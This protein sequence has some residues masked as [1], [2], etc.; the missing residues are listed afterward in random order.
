ME[1]SEGSVTKDEL[2]RFALKKGQVLLTKDS[3]SWDDIAIPAYVTDNM[4]EV[5][6]GYH[7]AIA[8]PFPDDLDGAYLAWLART[9]V[10]NDQF[11]L[12]ARGVTRFGLSQY[13]LKNA[14]L[15]VPP[16][17]EQRRIAE[18]LDEK[19]FEI[20]AL[21]E[22]KR[23]LLDLLAEKRSAIITNAVTKGINPGAPTK[24]CG[25]DWL[26]RVPAHWEVVSFKWR[27]S[28]TSG[29]VD[30]TEDEYAQLP[31][32]APDFIASGTGRLFPTPSAEE[33][34]AI[35]G[36]Y[37]FEAGTV[38]YSKIR[39]LLSKV[40]VAPTDGLC[41]ADMYPIIP[42]DAI[43]PKYLFYQLL[44][45]HFTSFAV[46][47]S[48]RVAMPKVNR[49]SLGRFPI[50]IP[51]RD[52]QEQI[53]Q[54]IDGMWKEIDGIRETIQE[55]IDRLEEY[56]SALITDAVTG[57]LKVPEAKRQGEAA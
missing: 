31:L 19:T 15:L 48:L 36:K 37:Y 8:E 43:N 5:V 50:L 52:E 25:I 42:S 56:R 49:E 55:V 27:C 34:G 17:R 23:S 46:M 21:I 32:V 41:S 24:D 39:P 28:V 1:F 14:E 53:I 4:P 2:D 29:Q 51:P 35:S 16:I 44:S 54:L 57:K 45:Q 20:D 10:V 11:K 3:E 47:E 26:G 12:A 33:Q 40:C 30:P 38:L 9:D 18:Y 13:A 7:L 22:K 6:C